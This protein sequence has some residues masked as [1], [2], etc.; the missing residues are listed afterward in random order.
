M[1]S[2]TIAELAKNL[3]CDFAGDGELSI[4]RA[5]HP[6]ADDLQDAIVV[7]MAPEFADMLPRD[8]ADSA[9]LAEGNDWQKLG[10]KAA[11]FTSRARFAMSAI[12]STF[13]KPLANGSSIHPSA[14]I[15]ESASLGEGAS[16][17]PFVVVEA[18]AKIGK[19][20]R[21]MSHSFVGADAHIGDDALIHSGVRIGRDV[22]IG[23]RVIIHQNAVIGAD[24][25][26][27]VTPEK[28]AVEAAKANSEGVVTTTN[29]AYARIASLAAVT[30]GDDVEVGA[31]STLDR[32]TLTDTRIGNGTK[33]DNQVQVAHNVKV[34]SGCLL[35]AQVGLA[36]SVEVG[37]RVVLGGKVGVA[38]HIKIGSDVLVAAASAVAS[39]VASR[40]IVMGI[41]AQ[42]RDEAMRSLMAIRR[43][44]RIIGTVEKLSKRFS[45]KKEK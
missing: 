38:D 16:V 17:G 29:T 30:L 45:E 21:I 42:K 22:T 23:D 37:D 14:L 18:G 32:G 13:E 36:G 9:V 6:K 12:T 1:T 5:V 43:L 33:I 27:F 3:G 31:C 39:N 28:G 24:G 34:G 35:C 15:D 10:L 44:P 19:N 11:I 41:P 26:S 8:G 2:I 40:N 25:F 4:S 7:A 20:A